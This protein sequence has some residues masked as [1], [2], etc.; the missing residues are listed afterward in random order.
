MGRWK[1][2]RS[3]RTLDGSRV[4]KPRA[5]PM[6]QVPLLSLA[7]DQLEAMLLCDREGLNQ[8][9]AA[10]RMGISRGTVQRLLKEGRMTLLSMI[11]ENCAL[12]VDQ[13]MTDPS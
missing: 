7:A 12:S 11:V 9:E 6:D 8:G 5:I 4:F 1:K 3:C 2:P 10:Q 13:S